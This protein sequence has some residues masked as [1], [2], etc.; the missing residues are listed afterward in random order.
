MHRGDTLFVM[1]SERRSSSVGDTQATVSKELQ[2]RLQALRDE[3][4]LV[5]KVAEQ[6]HRAAL[7]K[8]RLLGEE[9][10]RIYD[11][12][13]LQQKRVQ[14]A[15]EDMASNRRLADQGYV[16]KDQA[17]NYEVTV[18][19]QSGRLNSLKRDLIAGKR[20]LGEQRAIAD[21]LPDK[22][23]NQVGEIEQNMANVQ[24]DLI[25]NEVRRQFI[26]TAPQDGVASIVNGDVGQ[27][28]DASRPLVSIIPSNSILRAHLYV[29]SG[30]IGFIEPGQKALL[31]I[32][33]FPYQ[34]FGHVRALV[35]SVSKTAAPSGE[36]LGYANPGGTGDFL[37]EVVLALEAQSLSAFGA[38]H[39]LQPGMQLQATIM[40][41]RRRLFE[42]I[43]EP[44]YTLDVM[45]K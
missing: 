41:D 36:L 42:W 10:A 38:S 14:F 13:E 23:R 32:E 6:E 20:E 17:R 8:A 2:Q 24:R 22:A 37:Y 16:T 26:V 45:R 40:L 11:L 30:S 1:S 43:L 27:T 29:D 19:E 39:A 25:E 5:S 34:K 28:F 7:S 33:A 15:T 9:V 4:Q 44:L 35:L 3:R 18:I 21:T 31:R 12:I